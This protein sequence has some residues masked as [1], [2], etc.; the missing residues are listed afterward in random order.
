LASAWA[1]SQATARSAWVVEAEKVTPS[2]YPIP[3]PRSALYTHQ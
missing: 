3:G 1:A 2:G